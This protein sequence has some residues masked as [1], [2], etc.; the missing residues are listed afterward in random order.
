[1][2]RVPPPT[3]GDGLALTELLGLALALG[4]TEALGETD[5]LVL[6]D[7]DPAASAILN[8]CRMTM[9]AE[10]VAHVQAPFVPAAAVAWTASASATVRWSPPGSIV[11]AARF[12]NVS[13]L[14]P[15]VAHVDDS[16]APVHAM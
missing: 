11:D 2:I 5:G 6:E 12:V 15:A 13:V 4:L 9:F 16:S 3:L 1:M 7:G 14:V 10:A 8:A